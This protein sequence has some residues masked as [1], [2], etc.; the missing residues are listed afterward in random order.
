MWR[1]RQWGPSASR[2]PWRSPVCR[3]AFWGRAGCSSPTSRPERSPQ[4]TPPPLPPQAP[5]VGMATGCPARRRRPAAGCAA[6]ASPAQRPAGGRRRREG[7]RRAARGRCE[8]EQCLRRRRRRRGAFPGPSPPPTFFSRHLGSPHSAEK[9]VVVTNCG[10]KRSNLSRI[11]RG[12][13]KK[14]RV[15]RSHSDRRSGPFEA[16]TCPTGAPTAGAAPRPQ[17][18]CRRDRSP[19]FFL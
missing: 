19:F 11:R 8:P 7:I 15:Q 13:E 6:P 10:R 5:P 3:R 2:G 18:S 14:K 12:E 1:R 4:P 16:E 9:Q 17:S